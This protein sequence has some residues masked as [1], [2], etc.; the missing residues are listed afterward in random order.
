[1]VSFLLNLVISLIF[2]RNSFIRKTRNVRLYASYEEAKKFPRNNKKI[3][4]RKIRMNDM[5]DI[6]GNCSDK[7]CSK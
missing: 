2:E 3:T 7:S 4:I 1:M 6:N 5:N